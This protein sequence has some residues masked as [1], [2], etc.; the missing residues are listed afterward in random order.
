MKRDFLNKLCCP[1]DKQDLVLSV[2]VEDTEG[3]IIEGIFIC[4]CCNRYYPIVSGIPIMTPDEYR[5]EQLEVSIM[6]KWIDK[7]PQGQVTDF[8]IE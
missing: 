6:K 3:D 2:F 8:R 1:F 4:N 7:L 5:Q